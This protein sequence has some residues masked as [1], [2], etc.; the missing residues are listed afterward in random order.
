M[1]RT[2]RKRKRRAD[3]QE[4]NHNVSS[5]TS[6][7]E[8]LKWMKAAEQWIPN[9]AL[10]LAEFAPFGLRGF[11]ATCHIKPSEI[12]VR[13]PFKL[14][15]TREVAISFIKESNIF[16]DFSKMTT[17]TLLVIFLL[18]NKKATHILP[19]S[20]FWKPYL[21]TLPDAYDVPFFCSKIEVD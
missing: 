11:R 12:I 5:S 7:I 13:I 17:F 16:R 8:L 3:L 20:K 19:S 15:I 4:R 10:E 18:L 9:K 6:F 21:D 14:L 1:G 2:Q